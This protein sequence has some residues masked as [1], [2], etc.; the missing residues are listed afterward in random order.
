MCPRCSDQHGHTAETDRSAATPARGVLAG[1]RDHAGVAPDGGLPAA[2]REGCGLTAAALAPIGDGCVGVV[3]S[4]FGL[5]FRLG[6]S[7]GFGV[8]R[9]RDLPPARRARSAI[10]LAAACSD[11]RARGHHQEGLRRRRRCTAAATALG[12]AHTRTGAAK[13]SADHVDDGSTSLADIAPDF[14]HGLAQAPG[15]HP[16]PIRPRCPRRTRR[17][18]GWPATG[19]P[20][21]ASAQS[22]GSPAPRCAPRCGPV[23]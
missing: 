6:F 22:T 14:P 9:H 5:G 3:R 23:R 12:Q 2:G 4:R 17:P 16:R 10:A 13:R 19:Q 11:R 18:R 1:A 20:S 7:L 15:S 21:P 8:L